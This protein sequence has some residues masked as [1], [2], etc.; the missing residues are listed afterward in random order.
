MKKIREAVLECR[1]AIREHRDQLLDDR[2]WLDDHLIWAILEDSSSRGPFI[3]PPFEVL[4]SRCRQFYN[5]RRAECKDATP[6]D[7]ILDKTCWDKDLNDMTKEQLSDELL[8]IQEAIRCHRDIKDRSRTIDD[9]R[10]LYGVLPEKIPA[11]F[12]LPPEE[13]FLGEAKAPAAG[14]P[15]FWRSHGACP[16]SNHDF[17]GW[18]PCAKR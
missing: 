17:H 9:D 14:C 10:M 16:E 18:G 6:S 7:A 4:M 2:C 12:R 1:K 13:E 3:P 5:W 15:A 8:R 11:D